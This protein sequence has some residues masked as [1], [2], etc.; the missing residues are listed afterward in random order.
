MPCN[1][2]AGKYPLSA[3]LCFFA[4]AL[5]FPKTSFTI[6]NR[7]TTVL[8]ASF[9]AP[10]KP[11]RA[12]KSGRPRRQPPRARTTG[13]GLFLSSEPEATR[14]L[15][16]EIFPT[17]YAVFQ[18]SRGEERPKKIKN[19]TLRSLVRSCLYHKSEDQLVRTK[20]DAEALL[21]KYC[22]Q[23]LPQKGI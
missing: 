22:A 14:Q 2:A 10:R 17:L 5:T 19:R 18:Q 20:K 7:A 16:Y 12:C 4:T 11:R 13:G 8:P 23:L 9:T 21:Q 3:V 1:R 6:T 15:R